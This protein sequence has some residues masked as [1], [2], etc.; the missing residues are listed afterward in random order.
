MDHVFLF[1]NLDLYKLAVAVCRRIRSLNWPSGTTHLRDQAT[2]AAD[3]VV[4]NIAEGWGRGHRTPAGRNHL[5]IALGSAGEVFAVVDILGPPSSG[6]DFGKREETG[7]RPAIFTTE[8]RVWRT[9]ATTVMSSSDGVEGT[10]R[11]LRVAV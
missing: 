9:D 4:L 5:R 6:Q 10:P 11:A 3:S 7:R 1:E 2:R 8:L